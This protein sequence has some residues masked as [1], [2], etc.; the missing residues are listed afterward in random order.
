MVEQL[1]FTKQFILKKSSLMFSY[2]FKKNYPNQRN[3]KPLFCREI[4][5]IDANTGGYN[6]Q[7]AWSTGN[8]AGKLKN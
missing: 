6:F 7:S 4:I 8:I 3:Q 5:D 1:D 2:A